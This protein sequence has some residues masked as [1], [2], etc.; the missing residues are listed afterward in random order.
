M[1]EQELFIAA[2]HTHCMELKGYLVQT[3]LFYLCSV[4]TAVTDAWMLLRY[5]F[6]CFF[7]WFFSSKNVVDLKH[8]NSTE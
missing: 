4:V 8:N 5:V 7:S 6:H 2:G 3:A 1:G